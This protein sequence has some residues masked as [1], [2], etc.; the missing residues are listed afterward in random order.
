MAYDDSN[1]EGD[2]AAINKR[3]KEAKD[4]LAEW[5]QEAR[6]DFAFVAGHQW[7]ADDI[8]RLKEQGRPAVTFNRIGAMVDSVGGL[9]INNRQETR[10]YPREMG[11]APV[12]EI[13]TDAAKWARDNCQAE[14]E[15]SDAFQDASVSGIGVTESRM[16]YD[17]EP[18]G[19]IVIE[20]LDPLEVFW[21][22]AAKKKCLSDARYVF[23]ARWMDKSEIKER[24][25]GAEDYFY[26]DDL[27]EHQTPHNADRAFM[28]EGESVDEEV[29]KTQALVKHYQC[30]KLETYYRAADPFTG[31]LADLSQKQFSALQKNVKKMG[32]TLVEKKPGEQAGAKQI[33][34]VKS[35]KKVYYRAFLIGDKML[36]GDELER[37]P[38]QEGFTLKFITAKRDRNKNQWYGI[39]RSMKDPQRWGNKF[40]SQI[41]DI[42]AKNQKGGAFVEEG[43][44]IDARKAEEQ[45]ASSN[46]LILLK[47]GG[48]DKIKERTPSQYPSGLDRM[49]MFCFESIPFVS[50]INL[51]ALGLA[52]REQ[53]GV[54]EETRKKAAM[55]ILAPLF[56]ALRQYRREQG[57]VLLSYIQKYL[58]DG[59][60]IRIIGNSGNVKYVPLT[61]Q[62]D[63]LQY[64]VIVDQ[65][66]TSPDF[67]EKVW[68]ALNQQVLPIMLKNGQA[69]PPSVLQYAPLP[70][71][72]AAELAESMSGKLPPQV[73]QKFQEMQGALQKAGQENAKLSEDNTKLRL[74][75][76]VDMAK[77]QIKQKT[78]EQQMFAK[79]LETQ[80][81][82][83]NDKMKAVMDAQVA[84]FKAE[85]DAAVKEKAAAMQAAATVGQ[86]KGGEGGKSSKKKPKL[87]AARAVKQQDGSWYLTSE[88]LQ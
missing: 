7:A 26:T 10:F 78:D 50:G 76:S 81:E 57:K 44:L 21:D 38:C 66:P 6:E 73:E 55:A 49:M 33:S 68:A 52:N 30:Y 59:R 88:E 61:K 29:S 28:Y 17:E 25:P 47:E 35:K 42:M 79:M 53:A 65:S 87:R 12:N 4:G 86:D 40:F 67:R 16:D 69:I 2:V 77:L 36:G 13:L 46:P 56:G 43:A 22:P 37:S 11:D 15:E 27:K 64:D 1:L 54:L 19:K 85:L 60:L 84:M 72:V 18:D 32:L 51:E 48:I 5:R 8:A 20:R 71:D 23:A 14:D 45:W 63:T 34:Y 39:V 62:P 70:S 9:E 82:A 24:W 3:W 58:T 80:L 41:H 75:M 74:D 83:V 31:Q